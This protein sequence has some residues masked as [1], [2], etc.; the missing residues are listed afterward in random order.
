MRF[1]M[2][3]ICLHAFE[4]CWMSTSNI[5]G[6]TWIGATARFPNKSEWLLSMC[7]MITGNG[8]T[9]VG[10]QLSAAGREDQCPACTTIHP[11]ALSLMTASALDSCSSVDVTGLHVV[12]SSSFIMCFITSGSLRILRMLSGKS[13]TGTVTLRSS[14]SE[15]S[16]ICGSNP[17]NLNR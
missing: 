6:I 7:M 8:R 16:C 17:F 11:L 15:T 3:A 12:L 10:S 1:G 5:A 13:T 2:V 9:F 4:C 14:W